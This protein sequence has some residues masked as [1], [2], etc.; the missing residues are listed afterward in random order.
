[1]RDRPGPRR[2]SSDPGTPQPVRPSRAPRCVAAAF[3][4]APIPTAR[5]AGVPLRDGYGTITPPTG[6]KFGRASSRM[7]PR[8]SRTPPPSSPTLQPPPPS[9]DRVA[10]CAR[11]DPLRAVAS[12]GHTTRSCPA[13]RGATDS[14]SDRPPNTRAGSRRPRPPVGEVREPDAAR[15]R[16]RACRP[17]AASSLRSPSTTSGQRGE[18]PDPARCPPEQPRARAWRCTHRADIPVVRADLSRSSSTHRPRTR[19]LVAVRRQSP[20]DPR[21]SAYLLSSFHV[22]HGVEPRLIEVLLRSRRPASPRHRC[23]RACPPRTAFGA[24]RRVPRTQG[25][26]SAATH[27]ARH[28]PALEERPPQPAGPSRPGALRLAGQG[29][30]RSG[31]A[32]V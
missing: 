32:A 10:P 24:P 8:T 22:E 23:P 7:H 1:M 2:P 12:E 16:A 31:R 9:T 26:P 5:D 21:R 13:R 11:E 18:H 30:C 15:P 27:T 25:M 28:R 6:A 20:P 17:C 14:I 19:L 29:R 4:A 3:C